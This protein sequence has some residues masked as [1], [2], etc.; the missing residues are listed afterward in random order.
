MPKRTCH[1]KSEWATI[2]ANNAT[3]ASRVQAYQRDRGGN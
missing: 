3:D 2:D 1:T